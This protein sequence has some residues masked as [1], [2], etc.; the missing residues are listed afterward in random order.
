MLHT[1]LFLSFSKCC[2]MALHCLNGCLWNSGAKICPSPGVALISSSSD[3]YDALLADIQQRLAHPV[4]GSP[5]IV[6]QYRHTISAS[7]R[8][9]SAI[10][11]NRSEKAIATLEVAWRFETVDGRSYRHAYGIEDG[12]RVLLPFGVAENALKLDRYWNVILPGSKRY[13]GGGKM[14]GDNGD[15]R[16]PAPDE[17]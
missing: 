14:V 13:L 8:N 1:D 4:D 7:D 3:A 11:V 6:E 2:V 10:L 16:P 17:K 12:L 15:V 5:P 9:T